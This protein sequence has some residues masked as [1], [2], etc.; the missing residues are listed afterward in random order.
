MEVFETRDRAAIERFLRHHTAVHIYA[1][2]D[3]DDFFWPDTTWYAASVEGEMRALCLVLATLDPP[4]VYAL[5]ASGAEPLRDLLRHLSPGLPDRFF[6]NLSL[7]L[8][9]LFRGRGEFRTHGVHHKMLLEDRSPIEKLS[10]SG[11]EPLA[12][13]D[14]PELQRFF[15]EAA[16]APGEREA[17]FFE[18]YMLETGPY[19]GVREAG[20]LISVGGVHVHSLQQR[21]AAVGNLATRPD[22]RRRG[23]GRA[24]AAAVCRELAGSVDQIGLNVEAS[25]LGAIRCYEALGFRPVCSYLE[26]TLSGWRS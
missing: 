20:E 9:D 23:W 17:R 6:L 10:G 5:D 1:L 25:N 3:L 8:E 12:M 7:P 14:L 22:R 18:P 24:I 21:V 4:I 13:R 16:Y 11:V 2:A 19:F 26:A 15:R